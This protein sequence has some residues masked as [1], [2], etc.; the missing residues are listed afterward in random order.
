MTHR[1]QRDENQHTSEDARRAVAEDRARMAEA[2]RQAERHRRSIVGR[3]E[4][5]WRWLRNRQTGPVPRLRRVAAVL[6]RAVLGRESWRDLPESIATA[7]LAPVRSSRGS[8]PF[9][10]PRRTWIAERAA[11]RARWRAYAE[12][13]SAARARV[14]V[15]ADDREL[16]GYRAQWDVVEIRPEDWAQVLGEHRPDV[17]VVDSARNGNG[18]A[19]AYRI[20][21]TP[22][23]DFFL[24]RDLSALVAW[25]AA[26]SILT[27][28]RARDV[29]RDADRTWSDA[30]R[31]FDLIVPPTSAAAAAFERIADRRGLVGPVVPPDETPA[32]MLER[33]REAA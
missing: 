20:M 26:E 14:A 10:A 23:P 15:V 16:A 18:G 32:V 9:R 1:P 4:R 3:A 19:W 17:V 8:A 29:T 22:H 11:A 33:I 2:A 24:Q 21:W 7:F 12:R 13:P 25:C 6:A 31:H 27:V 5:G 28:F 30:A